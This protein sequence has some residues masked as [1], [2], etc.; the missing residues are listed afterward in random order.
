MCVQIWHP[1]VGSKIQPWAAVSANWAI[2]S[3]VLSVNHWIVNHAQHPCLRVQAEQDHFCGLCSVWL[4][5]VGCYSSFPFVNTTCN[6][7]L[8][9]AW[10]A[11]NGT[12][13]WT[14][15]HCLAVVQ[16]KMGRRWVNTQWQKLVAVHLCHLRKL[17]T[18]K[19]RSFRYFASASSFVNAL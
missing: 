18:K 7:T 13:S 12:S 1:R 14:F 3:R 16:S 2:I 19:V 15:L 17:V 6:L 9:Q 8:Q 10:A 11:A 5:V 4:L